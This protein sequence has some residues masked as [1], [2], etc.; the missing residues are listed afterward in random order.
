V[1]TGFLAH[2]RESDGGEQS[3]SD[4]LQGVSALAASN[5]SKIGLQHAG[6][7]IGLLHDLGKYSAAFQSYL[8]SAAGL[9]NPDADDYVDAASL[10]GKIDHSTAGAQY[11]WNYLAAQLNLGPFVGQ[12]LALRIASHYSG[13][14]DCI[15]GSGE[16]FGEDNF[17]R[18]MNKSRSRTFLDE[19][20]QEAEPGLLLRANELLND[21]QLLE[22]VKNL[23]CTILTAS[24]KSSIVASQ[25]LGLMVRF[26]FSCLI[27][28]DRTDTAD[29]ENKRIKTCRKSRPARAVIRR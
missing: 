23:A 5:A 25:Q 22:H 24:Q 4:H 17:A 15:S 12:M 20:V 10:K 6:E 2:H 14:I 8:R 3:V 26:L 19:V 18:R 16:S 7:L 29:F 11:I 21:S 13:L 9:A 28:A 27:D 1:S